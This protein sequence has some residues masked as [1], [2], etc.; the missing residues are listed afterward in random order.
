MRRRIPA[1]CVLKSWGYGGVPMCGPALEEQISG[2][3][4]DADLAGGRRWHGSAIAG[5]QGPR[6][7][8]PDGLA[9]W[10]SAVT[11]SMC[12]RPQSHQ[13]TPAVGRSAQDVRGFVQ[14]H[15]F[16][17]IVQPTDAR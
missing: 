7:S 10:L 6:R 4:Q 9:S 2:H 1:G 11:P 8:P 5:A 12:A 16:W 3:Q 17:I 14:A 15:E 13:V